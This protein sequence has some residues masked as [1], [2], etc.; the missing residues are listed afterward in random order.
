MVISRDELYK[1]AV[2]LSP[3]DKAQLVELLLSSFNYKGRA[4]I[5]AKWAVEAENRLEASKNGLIEK[6]SMEDVFSSLDI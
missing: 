6:V 3:L 2:N 1:E 5:D 4:D